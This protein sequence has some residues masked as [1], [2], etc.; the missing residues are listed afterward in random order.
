MD[1][2]RVRNIEMGFH[3]QTS[4]NLEVSP[5]A[6]H[7]YRTPLSC[8]PPAISSNWALENDVWVAQ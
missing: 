6:T 1:D 3:Q 5:R 4:F 7:K 8:K 2:N